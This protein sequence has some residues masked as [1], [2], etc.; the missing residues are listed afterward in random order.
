MKRII[1]LVAPSNCWKSSILKKLKSLLGFSGKIQATFKNREWHI[2]ESS[3]F[4]NK[5]NKECLSLMESNCCEF[6]ECLRKTIFKERK[7]ILTWIYPDTNL[8]SFLRCAV[9]YWYIVDLYVL[10]ECEFEYQDS[11]KKKPK[12]TFDPKILVNEENF[13]LLRFWDNNTWN[14]FSKNT[15]DLMELMSQD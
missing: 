6:C 1:L 9:A 3:I 2:L 5:T 7:R 12:Y 15:L 8:R 13:R 4:E 10:F 11:N 14:D